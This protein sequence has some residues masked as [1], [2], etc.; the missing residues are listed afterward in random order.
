M[1]RTT[2][3]WVGRWL[4]TS[5]SSR[6]VVVL[7]TARLTLFT[8]LCT[9]PFRPCTL[10]SSRAHFFFFLAVRAH[11]F[12]ITLLF[13]RAQTLRLLPLFSLT[14]ILKVWPLPLREGERVEPDF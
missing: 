13:T 6:L 5:P 2:D 10:L 14:L 1:A 11:T 7:A 3:G 9:P 8:P 12:T 4:G